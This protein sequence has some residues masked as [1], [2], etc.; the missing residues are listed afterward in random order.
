MKKHKKKNGAKLEAARAMVARLK[1]NRPDMELHH[2]FGRVGRLEFC[3]CFM[4]PLTPD[5][6]RGKGYGARLELLRDN[7]RNEFL[8][9]KTANWQNRDLLSCW[10]KDCKHKEGCV[11]YEE[12]SHG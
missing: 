1:L 11:L 6:H 12:V 4:V 2:V 3:P 8:E 7:M 9:M 5:D 10:W